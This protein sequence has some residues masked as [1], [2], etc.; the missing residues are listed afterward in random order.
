[1]PRLV[2]LSRFGRAVVPAVPIM[3]HA[4]K[5]PNCPLH[6]RHKGEAAS[7]GVCGGLDVQ[8][9]LIRGEALQGGA[10]GGAAAGGGKGIGLGRGN[11]PGHISGV[12]S[13]CGAE[14]CTGGRQ[15]P[16]LARI[17]CRSLHPFPLLRPLFPPPHHHAAQ[18]MSDVETR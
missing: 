1:M 13:A 9:D 7:G 5:G 2:Q 4:A 15:Y 17:A 12:I 3:D 18:V 11:S 8:H 6:G 14:V 16:P 10:R